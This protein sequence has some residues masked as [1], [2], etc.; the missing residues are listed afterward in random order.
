MQFL[1]PSSLTARGYI[2]INVKGNCCDLELQ[3]SGGAQ[4]NSTLEEPGVV[5][6]KSFPVLLVN[7]NNTHLL[8]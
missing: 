6:P 1:R 8:R 2:L 5:P 3:V 7:F 4:F